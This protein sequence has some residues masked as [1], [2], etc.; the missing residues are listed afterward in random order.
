MTKIFCIG[1]NKT[2]T[3]SLHEAFKI[4]GLNSIHDSYK[5][6]A[7]IDAAM[8]GNYKLLHYLNDY[9]AFS[10][11]PFFRYYKELDYEYPNS[12]FILNTRNVDNWLKSRIAHDTRWNNNNLSKPARTISNSTLKH[13]FMSVESDIRKYFEDRPE[14]FIEMNVEDG[15]GWEKLCGFIEKDVPNVSFPH[16]NK[17]IK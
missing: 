10:D 9:Q 3:S 7:L 13:F 4:L 2:G 17:T 16:S 12:K 6:N 5:S 15:D 14:D 11:Y 8:Q 1:H